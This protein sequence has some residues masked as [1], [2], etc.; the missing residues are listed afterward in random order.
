M[1]HFVAYHKAD[2]NGSWIFAREGE[3]DSFFTGKKYRPKTLIGNCL[4]VFE[5]SG[6]PKRYR[7]VSFGLMKKLRSRRGGARRVYFR[8]HRNVGPLDVNDFPWFQKLKQTQQSFRNGLNPIMDRAV[9]AALR[10]IFARGV[11]AGKIAE[12]RT[13]PSR[14]RTRLNM[15]RKPASLNEYRKAVHYVLG[16]AGRELDP[17][18]HNYQVRL[19]RFLVRKGVSSEFERN[20]ID[21][22]FKMK[23]EAYI[24]EIKNTGLTGLSEAFRMALGQLLEYAH[25]RFKT[26]PR[27]VMFLDSKLD[28]KRIDLATRLSVSVIWDTGREY[29]VLNPDVSA[30]LNRL[31]RD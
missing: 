12:S 17:K 22:T 10:R 23:R 4:W 18:H 16:S 19:K 25:L 29:R 14:G 24:G 6:S 1:R 13:H 8:T 2:E 11:N 26:P 9:V 15:I 3:L 5:G 7:L 27:M 21:V 30:S 31:F 28:D 20:F